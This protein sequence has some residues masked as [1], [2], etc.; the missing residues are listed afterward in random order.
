MLRVNFED[1]TDTVERDSLDGEESPHEDLAQEQ[2]E[3]PPEEMQEQESLLDAPHDRALALRSA[4]G[5]P[6]SADVKPAS[7]KCCYNMFNSPTKKCTIM[8]PLPGLYVC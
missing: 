5:P 4:P 2:E 8:E 7:D 3:F 6:G 1:F